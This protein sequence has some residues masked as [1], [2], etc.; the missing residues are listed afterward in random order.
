M[1]RLDIM[2]KNRC[3]V[4]KTPLSR[5]KSGDRHAV[6]HTSVKTSEEIYVCE[7]GHVF[8]GEGLVELDSYEI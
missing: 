5:V 7:K 1:G 2:D 3:F 8:S 6:E 4:C